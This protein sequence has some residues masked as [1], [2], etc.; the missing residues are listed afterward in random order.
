MH[1]TILALTATLLLGACSHG[2]AAICPQA[3]DLSPSLDDAWFADL[4]VRLAG[5]DRQNTIIEAIH[6][7]HRTHP[8]FGSTIIADVLIAADCPAATKA[9]LSEGDAKARIATLRAQIDEAL[10]PKN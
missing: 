4:S 8:E 10:P 6:T 1:K 9:T 2:Q 5:P 3:S 7:L